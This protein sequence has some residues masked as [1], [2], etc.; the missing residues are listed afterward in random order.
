MPCRLVLT[1]T[2]SPQTS[3][4]DDVHLEDIVAPKSAIDALLVAKPHLANRK[5]C[6]GIGQDQ[7]GGSPAFDLV[8]MLRQRAG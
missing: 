3:R 2:S 6:D 4:F 1:S 8:G 7:S 5:P